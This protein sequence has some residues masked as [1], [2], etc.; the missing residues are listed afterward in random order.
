M[1]NQAL[2]RAGFPTLAKL[3]F[4]PGAESH[5]IVAETFEAATTGRRLGNWGL[6]SSGPNVTVGSASALRRRTR[7]A[8]GN[9]PHMLSAV[10]SLVTNMVGA[11]IKPQWRVK[12]A[13]L[14][15]EIHLLWEDWVPESDADECSDFYGQEETVSRSTV[16]DGEVLAR[17]RPRRAEDGLAVPLQVQLLE[18]DHLPLHM[19]QLAANGNAIRAGIEFDTIGRRVIYH[20]YR[21]HPGDAWGGINSSMTSPVP[22]SDVM[23][24]RH[25]VRPGQL[26]G[27]TW[28]RQ[29][30]LS[31][32][33]LS[34]YSD[35]ERVRK[36]AAA[37]IGGFLV[38]LGDEGN[39]PAP[40]PITDATAIAPAEI[41]FEPGTFVPLRPGRDVRF[42]D[43]ADVGANTQAWLQAQLR[44][45]SVGA[46]SLYE[47]VTGDLTGVNFSSIRAGLLEFRR[48]IEMRQAHVI[49]QQFCRPVGRRWM[50]TAVLSAALRI[51]DYLRNRRTYVRVEWVPDGFEWVDPLKDS[52]ADV[53]EVRA[54]FCSRSQKILERGGNPD[55]VDRE[56]AQDRARAEQYGH[57]YDSD[58]AQTAKTG[59][60]Q[61]AEVAAAQAAGQSQ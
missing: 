13:D 31:L 59:V 7:Q 21:E 10:E 42:S 18:A 14:K 34:Q 39:P 2:S 28:M 32:H 36:K 55:T 60:I 3:G 9:D 11:G 50:D 33:E 26:R 56:N 53:M 5:K 19:T 45:I 57:V 40:G 41:A 15:E 49:V 44:E 24:V 30:L 46:G 48:R 23:H 25:I 20:I 29:I 6:D 47:L 4:D 22:A 8:Y 51:S 54:G 35:A 43:P 52:M 38:E 58:P 27:I 1:S 12:E 17:F 16:N 61:A 37:M